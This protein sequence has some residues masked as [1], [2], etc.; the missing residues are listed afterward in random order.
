MLNWQPYVTHAGENLDKLAT[1]FGITVAELKDINDIGN[2]ERVARGQ[3]ILV[4]KSA[5][6]DASEQQTLVAL[7]A[8]R[9]ADPVDTGAQ[10][11]PRKVQIAQPSARVVKVA[12]RQSSQT[13]ADDTPTTYRVARG[14]TVFNIAKRYGIS[15]ATLKSMNGLRNNHISTGQTLKLASNGAA[16]KTSD[17]GQAQR[18]TVRRGDTMASIAHKH[19]VIR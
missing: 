7:A 8:N 2:R 17:R 15:V 3:T 10:D 1:S 19:N 18:Y 16:H 4:P 13:E 11:A 9:A 12:L 6:I 14:D 5:D